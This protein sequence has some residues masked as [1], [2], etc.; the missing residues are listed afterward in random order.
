[1]ISF[2]T[3]TQSFYGYSLKALWVVWKSIRE[4]NYRLKKKRI[5]YL[6]LLKSLATVL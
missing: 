3:V 1:M 4:R 2:C 6:G 5:I